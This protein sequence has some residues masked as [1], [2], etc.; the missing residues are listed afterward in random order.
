MN[1]TNRHLLPQPIVDAV[2]NDGYSKG[3]AHIS[4]TGLIRPPRMRALEARH[5][6]QIETDVVDMIWSLLGQSIHEVL[7]RAEPAKRLRQAWAHVVAA[8]LAEASDAGAQLIEALAPLVEKISKQNPTGRVAEQRLETTLDGWVI[9]GEADLWHED[10]LLDDYKVTTVYTYQKAMEG[11]KS[12]WEQQLN[13]YAWLYGLHSMPVTKLR[14]VAIL[15]DWKSS[16]VVKEGYPDKQVKVV[17]YPLWPVEKTIAFV[18]ERIA[19]HQ[20]VEKLND[21]ELPECTDEEMWLKPEAWAVRKKGA[22]KASKV[23]K[24]QGPEGEQQAEAYAKEKG[25]AYEVEHRLGEATR[26][27]RFCSAAPFCSQLA[28]YRAAAWG[29]RGELKGQDEKDS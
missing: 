4:A 9:S 25:E 18:K 19:L 21:D 6:A 17:W 14:I 27:L 11:D 20:S 5:D 23:F 13:I 24:I 1:I 29:G 26:C 28:S 22:A 2:R 15:R 8:I 16:E 10:G 7:A 12:E 3:K